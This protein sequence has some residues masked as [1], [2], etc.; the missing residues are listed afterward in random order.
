MKVGLRT[1][2]ILLFIAMIV[3]PIG[4]YYLSR[5]LLLH[6]Y[7]QNSAGWEYMNLDL[8]CLDAFQEISEDYPVL[9]RNYE[10][11]DSLVAPL[12]NE[13]GGSLTILDNQGIVLYDSE[14]AQAVR[15][16]V[17]RDIV[18][19]AGYDP[20]FERENPG[21]YK[22]TYPIAEDGSQ[23]ATAIIIKSTREFRNGL[24]GTYETYERISVLLGGLT[25]VLTALFSLFYVSRCILAPLKELNH[26]LELMGEG[27]LD[28]EITYS[29]KDEFGAF[30]RAFETM[31]EKLKESL[32]QQN[33][34]E[35]SRKEA[36]AEI[37]H[38]LRTPLS[39]ILAYVEGLEV[40]ITRD[41]EQFKRYLAVI[42]SKAT[43]L[44]RLIGDLLLVTQLD[45][46]RFPM[47]IHSV[48]SRKFLGDIFE[49]FVLQC[50]EANVE[51]KLPSEIPEVTLEIDEDRIRQV[52]EN[53]M[54]NACKF[55]GND[56]VIAIETGRRGQ[57]LEITVR[58]NGEGIAKEE[59]PH[60]FDK[61]FRSEKS[62]SR[63]HG[64]AGLGLAICK[65]I[66]AGHGGE[67][68]AESEPG[69]GTAISFT[70]PAAD[71]GQI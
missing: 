49:Q 65:E 7:D 50:E 29:R 42:K 60:I 5:G 26:G 69:K 68:R 34:Y 12:L 4:V 22:H 55:V 63:D 18:S 38:E 48:R 2:V 15:E 51:L 66:V 45:L 41:E 30:C 62:R 58:D 59:L 24:G 57:F 54:Q 28:F 27:N 61:F 67:I 13:L 17:Q 40:G 47:V 53:L 21:V 1:K 56:G 31:R 10:E 44:N 46:G 71:S 16:H 43:A 25:L 23:V 35:V 70:L 39:L 20:E 8:V 64:G 11:F 32:E 52:M 6:N 37:T 19:M 9:G 33:A 3:L 36:L 14:G